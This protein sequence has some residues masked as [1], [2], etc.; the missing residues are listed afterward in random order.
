MGVAKRRFKTRKQILARIPATRKVCAEQATKIK[1]QIAALDKKQ[2]DD[3]DEWVEEERK[4][5]EAELYNLQ[6]GFDMYRQAL[7]W[8]LG[9]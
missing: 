3:F 5:L 7:L 1:A 6:K 8:V 2:D 4:Q 9:E